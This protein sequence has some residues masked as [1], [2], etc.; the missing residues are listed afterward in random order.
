MNQSTAHTRDERGEWTPDVPVPISP[1]N[2]WP[3]RPIALARWLGAYPGYIWPSNLLCLLVTIAIWLWATPDLASMKT[4]EAWWVAVLFVRNLGLFLFTFGGLHLLLYVYKQQ[5]DDLRF[6]LK[7]FAKNN[8]RFKFRNQL[9][10]NVFRTLAYALPIFTA[11]EAV[12]Y[13]GFANG[14]FGFMPFG[15][16]KFAFWTWTIV[17]AFSVPLIHSVH[18]YLIHRLLHVRFLYRTVHVYHHHNIEVSPWSGLAMHP[19]EILLYFSSVALQW[20]LALHPFNAVLQLTLA[21]YYA[22]LAHSGFDKVHL[23]PVK[24]DAGSFYHYLHHKHFECNYGGSVIAMDNWFGSMHDGTDEARAK[25]RE[26][27]RA[28]RANQG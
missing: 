14:H 16:D 3:P 11:L 5:G 6:T 9:Y 12:S 24:I 7:P 25:I 19:L 10:D 21:A 2:H 8:A 22:A 23:G 26:R 27:A 20:L 13:W 28:M 4:F 1:L 17:M 18:F 15:N